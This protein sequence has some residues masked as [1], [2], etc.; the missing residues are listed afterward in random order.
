MSP[1]RVKRRCAAHSAWSPSGWRF[2]IQSIGSMGQV[3]MTDA[4]VHTNRDSWK[5]D[6]ERFKNWWME[7]ASRGVLFGN[8][9]QN[10][11]FFTAYSNTDEEIEHALDVAE[12]AFRAVAD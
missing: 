5:A 1:N 6:E 12:E 10:E 11:R 4:E 9:Q 3:F 8:H 7:C 2:R